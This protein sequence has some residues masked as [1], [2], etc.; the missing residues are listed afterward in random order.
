MDLRTRFTLFLSLISFL[1]LAAFST[2][3]YQLVRSKTLSH[4]QQSLVGFLEH[5]WEH[6]DLPDHQARTKA[7]IPH[8]KDVYLRIR[9]EGIVLYDSFQKGVEEPEIQGIDPERKRIFHSLIR[10]HNGH[11]YEIIGYFD[12]ISTLDYLRVLKN[13]LIMGSLG[14]LLILIPLGGWTT[15]V[16]L[17]PFRKLAA[18]T[19][20]INAEKLSYRFDNPK[21]RD[22]YGLLAGNFNSLLDRLEQS[23]LSV[24][25]FASSASHELRT[26][27]AVIISQAE[28]ALRREREPQEY[29]AVISKTL[30]RAK[31]LRDIINRLLYLSEVQHLEEIERETIHA[32]EFVTEIANTLS[33]VYQNE[34]KH[35]VIKESPQDVE[36]RAN[37]Q[38][39]ASVVTNLAENALK[40][41]AGRA[42]ISWCTKEGMLCLQIDDD[43]PGIPADKKALVFEPFIKLPQDPQEK[44]VLRSHG[45]GLSIVRACLHALKGS[46]EL[47]KSSLGG[48]LVQVQVPVSG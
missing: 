45:L 11:K 7:G 3:V 38:M 26:P 14:S 35:L 15:R 20:E 29:R 44:S 41:S 36:I 34:G 28:M 10:D 22:E 23:F 43:G 5:E 21:F 24:R 33:H 32:R 19:S 2:I 9:K 12:L 42:E 8:F 25:R 16:L 18:K 1:F 40:Y 46:I 6:I 39:L 27:L 4:E 30:D 47:G 37:R 17:K 48:L 31:D 13:I